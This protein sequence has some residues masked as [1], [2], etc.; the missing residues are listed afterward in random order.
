VI[1]CSKVLIMVLTYKKNVADM[2]ESLVSGIVEGSRSCLW[3]RGDGVESGQVV[4][5]HVG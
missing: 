4:M 2:R 5:Y 3:L 1:K